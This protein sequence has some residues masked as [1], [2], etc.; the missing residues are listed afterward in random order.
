MIAAR[1]KALRKT[2]ARPVPAS[3]SPP[4]ESAVATPTMKRKNGNT[5]SVGVHPFHSAC[6][7]GG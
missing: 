3:L 4:S 5:R 7:S 1:T 2:W 6:S